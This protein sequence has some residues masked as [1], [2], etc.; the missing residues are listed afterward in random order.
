MVKK[1]II[2]CKKKIKVVFFFLLRG[3][4]VPEHFS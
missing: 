1:I 4:V 2:N 3:W